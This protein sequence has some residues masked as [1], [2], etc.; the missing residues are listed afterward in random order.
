MAV[1]ERLLKPIAYI[2]TDFKEKFGIPRQSNL[3]PAKGRIVFA[4]EYRNEDA[5]RGLEEYNYIWLIWDFSDITD[6]DFHPTVR[7]PRLGGNV[8]KGVFA[9][10]SPF[11]PNHLGLSCVKLL[12]IENSSKGPQLLVEGVDMLDGTPIYD[13]K[14]YLPYVDVRED[15]IGSFSTEKKNYALEVIVSEELLGQ[16]VPD[17]REVLVQILAQDPRPSYQGDPDRIYGMSFA[18]YNVKFSVAEGK[19]T[20]LNVEEEQ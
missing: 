6:D 15:A 17:K 11:R 20:V 18:G 5:L 8:R 4:K 9:T 14:P 10:R 1:R 7:P 19:L 12:S 13:I 16:I 3:A 2:Y